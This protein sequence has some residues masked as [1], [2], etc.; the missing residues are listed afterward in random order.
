MFKD[1]I[2]ILVPEEDIVDGWNMLY[3]KCF[4]Y[5]DKKQKTKKKKTCLKQYLNNVIDGC[6]CK[7]LT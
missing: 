3:K 5:N 2:L 1:L 7:N 6:D 4:M